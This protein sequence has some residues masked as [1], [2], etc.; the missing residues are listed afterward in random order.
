M[1]LKGENRSFISVFVICALLT[2]CGTTSS[3]HNNGLELDSTDY[4]ASSL[5]VENQKIG[6]PYQVGGRWYKPRYETDYDET[7]IASWYGDYFHGRNTANGEIF[8]MNKVSA[9][10]KT[11][12][13]PSY[14]EVTNLENNQK[15]YVRVNDRGPFE[16]GRIIDLSK[17]A[18]DKLGFKG[19]GLARVRVRQVDPPMNVVLVSPDGQKQYGKG[20][21]SQQNQ[22]IMV[23]SSS[24]SNPATMSPVANNSATSQAGLPLY[25]R[26]LFA[27]GSM[28]AY[29]GSPVSP[30]VVP[31]IVASKPIKNPLVIAQTDVKPK[32]DIVTQIIKEEQA[33]KAVATPKAVSPM[34][35]AVATPKTFQMASVTSAYG[36]KYNVKVGVF[37][38][39]D[40]VA[41]LRRSL[42][43]LGQF[44]VTPHQK[45]GQT[46]SVVSLGPF[47]DLQ[48]AR[49][50]VDA[51]G[52]MGI[53]DADIV[54]Q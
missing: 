40:N 29:K 35:I 15:L 44:N 32:S 30:N 8:N 12:P 16:D 54:S 2:A 22:E 23:A 24:T 9:A 26:K 38:S 31:V 36:Q 27:G 48:S 33:S 14:V 39:P 46:L 42:Q 21:K 37:S 3:S 51:L 5:R 43:N 50:T 28:D 7:G 13:L 25:D 17:K 47:N 49:N 41:Q 10:H 52:K 1:I 53:N 20:Y 19:A 18:A 6:K 4:D 34:G 11:L 45:N